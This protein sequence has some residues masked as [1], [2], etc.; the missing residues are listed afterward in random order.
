[1]MSNETGRLVRRQE[2]SLAVTVVSLRAATGR[3][4]RADTGSQGHAMNQGKI[5]GGREHFL[6]PVPAVS[7]DFAM[8]LLAHAAVK[9]GSALQQRSDV[10]IGL[11]VDVRGQVRTA[12]ESHC[13]SRPKCAATT[14]I[15]RTGRSVICALS[16]VHACLKLS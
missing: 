1:M 6:G 8:L 13:S 12:L 15:T 11:A 3:H 16:P 4:A 14:A 9:A 7:R 10:R 2:T 5:Y